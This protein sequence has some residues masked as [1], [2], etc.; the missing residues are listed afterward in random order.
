[1]SEGSSFMSSDWLGAFLIIALLFNGGGFFGGNRGPMPN[2]A[3][4]EDVQNAVN[5]QS[6]QA[7]RTFSC[8]QPITT[9]RQL[10]L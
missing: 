2:F 1:M 6:V 9:T 3:T 8:P 10:V 4:A 7:F 5:N